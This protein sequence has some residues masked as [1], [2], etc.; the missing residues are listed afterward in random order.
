VAEIAREI[1]NEYRLE[2]R[3]LRDKG[4]VFLTGTEAL[5]GIF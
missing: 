2:Y 4:T 1:D 3:Y 5:V